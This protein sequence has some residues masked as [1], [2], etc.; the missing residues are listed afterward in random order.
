MLVVG[1][2]TYLRDTYKSLF[3]RLAIRFLF[4]NWVNLLAPRYGSATPRRFRF[5]IQ[6]SQINPDPYHWLQ[7][8]EWDSTLSKK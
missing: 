2:I 5:R 8:F 4:V 7:Y 1:H 6:E 3:D